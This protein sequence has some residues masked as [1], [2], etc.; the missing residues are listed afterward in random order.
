MVPYKILFKYLVTRPRKWV[1]ALEILLALASGRKKTSI[2]S[3]GIFLECGL[4]GG[5]GVWCALT[6][7]DYE[8]ELMQFLSFLKP[9]DVV[10]D[11]GANIGTFAIRSAITIEPNGHVYAFE[12]LAQ[13]QEMLLSSIKRNTVEN[14]SVINSAVGDRNG[15]VSLISEGRNSSAKIV[16]HD[17]QNSQEVPITTLDS[18]VEKNQISRL[19]W[20]KMDIEGAEPLVLKGMP[21]CLQKVKPSFLFENHE[22]GKETCKILSELNY[23]I[24]IFD[25]R[26]FV[27]SV[28]SE[29]LFAVPRN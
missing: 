20:I 12:P 14:I 18:F 26:H 8:P 15:V 17:S 6:G 27:E 10:F 16:A 9:N 13:N 28:Q 1:C 24:G 3:D 2:Y 7:F 19:D 4:S 11:V 21:L 25:G 22:G 23:K 5:Q 29:N